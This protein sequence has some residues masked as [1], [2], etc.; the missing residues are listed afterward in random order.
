MD[1]KEYNE[2]VFFAGEVI[3]CVGAADIEFLKRRARSNKRQRVRLCAHLST[4]EAVHEMLIVHARNTYVR[5]HKHRRKSESFHIIEGEL[6]VVIF[7]DAGNV[8]RVIA[9]GDYQSD[10][11]FYYRL[12]EDCFHTVVPVSD[13][14]VF[15][16]TTGGPF[17]RED[18]IF[19]DWAP[20][21]D[22]CEK[23]GPYLDRLAQRLELAGQIS[24]Q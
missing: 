23:Q 9:M 24:K 21:D 6:K 18:T 3:A 13:F 12:G 22:E 14:V 4:D 15:H 8:A 1:F 2:E 16:E 20:R 7:D 11:V 17:R 5:P 19:A 10:K